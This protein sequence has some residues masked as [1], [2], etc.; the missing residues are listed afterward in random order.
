MTTTS[1]RSS[2]RNDAGSLRSDGR[3]SRCDIP[4]LLA[5]LAIAW[6]LHLSSPA[7]AAADAPDSPPASLVG[8][9]IADFTLRDIQGKERSLREFTEPAVVVVFLGTDCPLAK[10]YAPRLQQIHERFRERG[11]AVLAINANA[12]DSLTEVAAHARRHGLTFP[13]LKDLD[14]RVADAFQ[15]TRT[16][17]AFLLDRDRV[18][19][20]HGRIDDQYGVG[21]QRPRPT[22]EDLIVAL[23]QLLAGQPI[24]VSSTTA[25]GCHLGRDARPTPTGQLTYYKH[26]APLLNAR[27]V[28]CHRD[29]EIA[30]FPLS[31]YEDLRGWGST[32]A[33]VVR[34]GRMPPWNASPDYG[35]FRND[36]R[37]S[38]AERTLLLQWIDEGM[39]A[40]D[41][42]DAPPPPQFTTGWRIPAPDQ[43]IPIRETP[44]D[45]PA[46]GTI[47]Y[48]YFEVDPGFTE[49]KYVY[50]AE[51]RPD[52]R[53]VVHH[54]IAFIKAP[55]DDDF[56]RRGILIGYAPGSAA[57]IYPGGLA[58]LVPAGSKL[59][60]EMH[61]TANGSPQQDKSYIGLKFLD[62][63]R[64]TKLVRNGAVMTQKFEI[65]PHATAHR[66]QADQTL[67]RDA[68]LLSL[69]PHMHV[70]GK[71]FRYSAHYPDGRTEIL[72]DVPR[73]DFNWQLS[74][75][76]AEPKRLPRGTRIACEAVY[77]NSE[78]NPANPDPSIAVRWGDQ[79]WEEMMIGFF[80]AIAAD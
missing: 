41:P 1:V 42:A 77:D 17:E 55:G 6:F 11:V 50:A 39:A 75:A 78:N 74:Y 67:P 49:D 71:S 43:V 4:L 3:V 69:T 79:S 12:Q 36:A 68:L 44:V 51:A 48:Q 65:P 10:L 19:R 30:P 29:G 24:A 37:L 32:M 34:E 52:N 70:R 5:C 38:Q 40:G 45:I 23:E 33:E 14:Q 16:P 80:D 56:R 53:S 73:Y 9:S 13:V 8:R 28:S 21:V 27:C 76:F 72:L 15:A 26:I 47:P 63:A 54:I 58:K 18:I 46:E 66:V 64:V 61:Y 7:G 20:Y 31:R 60:F 62:R 35:H 59:V 25:P 22:R 2:S 57:M